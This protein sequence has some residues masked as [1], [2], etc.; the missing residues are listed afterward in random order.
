MV[1]VATQLWR[2][3]TSR[4]PE[5]KPTENRK[6]NWCSA[7]TNVRPE[8]RKPLVIGAIVGM[9]FP[10]AW[11]AGFWIN[12]LAATAARVAAAFGARL[13]LWIRSSRGSDHRDEDSREIDDF[14]S[15]H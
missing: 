6:R 3:L 7:L 10:F 13:F 14:S 4:Q 15:G 5:R 11:P 1:P 8:W 2:A 9:A 12:M